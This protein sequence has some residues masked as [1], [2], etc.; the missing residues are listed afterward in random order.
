MRKAPSFWIQSSKKRFPSLAF[1]DEKNYDAIVVGG[2]VFGCTSAYK[3]KQEGMKVALVEART[4]GSGVSSYSTAKLTAQHGNIYST[5]LKTHNFE[6]AQNYY[7]MNMRGITI[8]EELI[9]NLS[10]D[11]DHDKRNHIVWTSVP[12]NTHLIGHEFDVCSSLRIPCKLLE[13]NDLKKE[14]PV[15]INPILGLAFESQSIFNPHKY[16]QELA[17]HIQGDGSDVF[18]HSR[19]TDI[20]DKYGRV[21]VTSEEHQCKLTADKVVVATHLPILDRSFHFAFLEP[22]KSHCIA[23]RIKRSNQPVDWKTEKQE[24]TEKNEEINNENLSG[25]NIRNMFINIDDPMRSMRPSYDGDILVVTGESII[26]GDETDTQHHYNNL[27]S[28]A[29]QHFQV[30]EVVAQWSGMDYY[31]PDHI[32]YIGYL[33]GLSDNLFTGTGF[34]TWG[35]AAGVAGGEIIADLIQL[36]ENPYASMVNARSFELNKQLKGYM[37]EYAHSGKHFIKDKFMSL[38]TAKHISSLSPD[39]GGIVKAGMK[40]VGAYRDPKGAYHV[41]HPVCTHLGCSLLFNSGDKLWDCPCHG[42]QFDV[43]GKVIHGPAVKNLKQLTDL[44][45]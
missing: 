14:L 12:E 15:S 18:E 7:R 43:D 16:C 44:E 11:C 39:Q 24:K 20:K 25:H 34:S 10:L 36:R 27:I 41:V 13:S 9:A 32:P 33:M 8:V 38:I 6:V 3:L 35:L 30:E 1:A 29:N 5:L 28:W 40:T 17:S 42:S 45:W 21:S 23:V 26:Q 2:G 4:I 37:E 19:V 22:S 31:S